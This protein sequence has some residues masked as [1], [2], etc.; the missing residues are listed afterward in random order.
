MGVNQSSEFS[1][2]YQFFSDN[3]GSNTQFIYDPGNDTKILFSYDP[4]EAKAHYFKV[5]AELLASNNNSNVSFKISNICPCHNDKNV[6]NLSLSFRV[7]YDVEGFFNKKFNSK[8]KYF[9]D[10]I[11]KIEKSFNY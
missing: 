10:S 3:F 2:T 7:Y 9:I 11:N 4:D 5:N 8:D 6:K 1:K